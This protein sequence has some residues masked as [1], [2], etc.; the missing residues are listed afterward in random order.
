[1]AQGGLIINKKVVPLQAMMPLLLASASFSLGAIIVSA[2]HHQKLGSGYSLSMQNYDAPASE[3]WPGAEETLHALDI[4][5]NSLFLVE[6][7]LRLLQTNHWGQLVYGNLKKKNK[8][9]FGA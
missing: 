2:D 6:L 7:L 4:T 9:D 5:F 3:T 8:W 1:M